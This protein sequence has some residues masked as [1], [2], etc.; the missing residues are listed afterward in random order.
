MSMDAGKF[1]DLIIGDKVTNHNM[2]KVSIV[3]DVINLYMEGIPLGTC[4][5]EKG[6]SYS[7][8]SYIL[9]ENN[10]LFSVFQEAKKYSGGALKERL[11]SIIYEN[12]QHDTK[13][14]KWLLERL[15]PD[16]FGK[17][18]KQIIETNKAENPEVVNNF[19]N[20]DYEE[21]EDK[22]DEDKV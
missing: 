2:D 7:M 1:L 18:T 11:L 5:K 9:K 3:I 13:D 8:F 17:Q 15:Y 14:A 12:A 16:E 22:R 19:I 21:I 20:A 4:L 10:E 6:I